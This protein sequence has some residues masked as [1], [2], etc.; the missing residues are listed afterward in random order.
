MSTRNTF[1]MLASLAMVTAAQGA[2]AQDPPGEP[3]WRITPS[4]A[5]PELVH[6][7]DPKFVQCPLEQARTE[8][9][10]ELPK[11]W[12]QTPFVGP[13]VGTRVQ[14]VGD[15]KLLVCEY[16]AYTAQAGVMMKVPAS[17]DCDAVDGGFNCR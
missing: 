8:I 9:V 16:Q 7:S 11:G 2:A 4:P 1:V 17:M 6:P 15:D 5:T 13:L 12:W 10:S 14:I 3:R